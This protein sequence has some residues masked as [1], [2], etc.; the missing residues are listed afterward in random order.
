MATRETAT[1]CSNH[2][3]PYDMNLPINWTVAKLKKEISSLEFNLTSKTIPTCKSALI[4]IYEQMLTTK[5]GNTSVTENQNEQTS[6]DDNV[7][8]IVS[9]T[10][11]NPENLVSNL[12][13]NTS[14]EPYCEKTGLRGFRPGPTQTWLCSDR[15][16][17]EA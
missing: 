8:S 6:A 1:R 2:V 13:E 14:N 7:V 17:L 10:V 12:P 3:A 5:N 15:R 4:Q 11:T 9:E 16:R